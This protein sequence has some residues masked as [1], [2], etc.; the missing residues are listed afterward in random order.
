MSTHQQSKPRCANQ[1]I[2]EESGRP[3]TLKSKVGC[4]AIDEP[5]TKSTIGLPSG[6]P[7]Y[8]SHRKSR[9]SPSDVCL[10]VH[11]STPVTLRDAL[12][13]FMEPAYAVP[14]NAAC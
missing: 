13:S 5:C 8:F 6:E 1:S 7:A 9:T 4:E 2:T 14:L 12:V 10:R 3:G 11:C